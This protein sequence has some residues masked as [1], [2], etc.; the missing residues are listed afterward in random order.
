MRLL[1]PRTIAFLCLMAVLMVVAASTSV[2]RLDGGGAG[3]VEGVDARSLYDRVHFMGASATA[4]FGVRAP[5]PEGHPSRS[6]A[7]PLARIAQVAQV[8][9]DRQASVSGDATSLFFTSPLNTGKA[10]VEGVLELKERPT[11][12]VGV[13]Y[14][15]WYV[16]GAQNADRARIKDEGERLALLEIG[17]GNLDRLVK[18][19]IPVAVGDIP[20]MSA[21]VGRMLSPA[22][23]PQAATLAKA[24]ERIRAWAAERPRVAIVPLAALV[25]QLDSDKPFTAGNR[26]WSTKADGALIQADRLHPTFAGSVALLARA[27]QSVNEHFRRGEAPGLVSTAFEHD[28]TKVAA[29]MRERLDKEAVKRKP[30]AP[31]GGDAAKPPAG[32]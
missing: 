12:V 24:N 28:P 14:L 30:A 13:D 31:K 20:D 15:F 10:Q 4:G 16:Y 2:A 11:L 32:T 7:M 22:Q 9:R 23:M 1:H 19:G 5:L 29:A 18:A 26:T 27:E 8:P 21:A 25:V 3:V 6:Q 17:L